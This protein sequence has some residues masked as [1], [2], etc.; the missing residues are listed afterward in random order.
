MKVKVNI[1]SQ[2]HH[3]LASRLVMQANKKTRL[4]HFQLKSSV[5]FPTRMQ[6]FQLL[7]PKVHVK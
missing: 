3:L 6:L 7:K 5:R 4:N 2:S 1:E